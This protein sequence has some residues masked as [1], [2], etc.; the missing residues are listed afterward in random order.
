MLIRRRPG[1]PERVNPRLAAEALRRAGSDRQKLYS[2]Y[3]R[4]HYQ[5]T[6]SLAPGCDNRDLQAWLEQAEGGS[7]NRPCPERSGG[8]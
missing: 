2:E 3:I 5:S 4:L 8:C 7:K 6:G 1:R